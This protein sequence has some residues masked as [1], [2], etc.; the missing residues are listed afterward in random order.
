VTDDAGG[1][2]RQLCAELG[3][4]AAPAIGAPVMTDP[5]EQARRDRRRRWAELELRESINALLLE[6]WTIGE[7][8]TLVLEVMRKEPAEL[9]RMRPGRTGGDDAA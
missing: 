7:I 1:A 5:Q 4:H 8:S 9:L 3:L 6:G 2:I